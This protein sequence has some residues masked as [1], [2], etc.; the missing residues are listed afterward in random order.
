[1]RIMECGPTNPSNKR[2]RSEISKDWWKEKR[3]KL[4]KA[5]E[6]VKDLKKEGVKLQKSNQDLVRLNHNIT[7]KRDELRM[8]NNALKSEAQAAANEKN[9]IIESLAQVQDEQKGIIKQL[10]AEK[11]LQS[12]SMERTAPLIKSLEEYGGFSK[13]T[14]KEARLGAVGSA[15]LAVVSVIMRITQPIT[16][17][18]TIC[19]V[20]FAQAIFGAEVT[21]KVLNEVY[22]NIF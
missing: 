3:S 20:L 16:Q 9:R 10:E 18:W 19:E 13:I 14:E 6:D 12:E 8:A 7:Q 1:M 17:L 4:T 5:V 11:Q 22:R 21:G 2:T 15:M